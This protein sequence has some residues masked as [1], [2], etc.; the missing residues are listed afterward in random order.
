[1]VPLVIAITAGVV[2][3]MHAALFWFM[4]RLTRPDLYFAVTVAHGFRESAEGRSILRRYRAELVL[5]TA[6]A[7]MAFIAGV[8]WLGVG[9][10]PAGVFIQVAAAFLAFYRAR[11]RVL[12]HSVPPT[13]IRE[14]ELHS[15]GRTVPHGRFAASAPFIVL[16]V[17]AAYLWT[18][19]A[20]IR[21]AGG[22]RIV[23]TGP[24]LATV[25]FLSTG[26]ILTALTLI[27]YG[28]SHWVR[29]V[30]ARGAEHFTELKFRRTSSTIILVVEYFITLQAS[31]I[32]L[33]PRPVAGAPEGLVVALF[34]LAPV[35]AL[36]AIVVLAH[37]GQGGVRMNGG[38]EAG[39]GEASAPV[40]DRTRDSCWKLGIFYF[41]RD[42]SAALVE[43]RF[44]LGYTLNFARPAA[45]VIVL[46]V[47]LG[48]LVP[49]LASRLR[50]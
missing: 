10:V 47:M 28:M 27:R 15:E 36:V 29:S 41:N 16:G 8:F 5:V 20:S 7:L 40:G 11:R 45:W 3:T 22:R 4:P 6:L 2:G 1:V 34:L 30:H 44:G 21:G 32:C 17:C 39:S 49:V 26:G 13:T 24:A 23:W 18:H 19:G 14:A 42:D 38:K 43:R 9:F 35:L 50:R 12:P 31:W 25:Y 46:L 37:L 33:V 48:P